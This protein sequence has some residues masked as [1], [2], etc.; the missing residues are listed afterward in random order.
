MAALWSVASVALVALIGAAV[1]G[2]AGFVIFPVVALA[3]AALKARHDNAQL[4]VLRQATI[5]AHAEA[6]VAQEQYRQATAR[7]ESAKR[8]ARADGWLIA[9]DPADV[10]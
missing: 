7:L 6:V 8:L 5:A 1:A 10:N 2:P 3:A 4:E 9:D